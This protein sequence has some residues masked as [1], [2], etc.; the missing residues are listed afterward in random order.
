MACCIYLI[1][2]KVF[3]SAHLGFPGSTLVKN[4]PANRGNVGLTPRWG[5]I[6]WRRKW[7]PTPVFLPGKFYGHRR[8]M[9]YSPWDCKELDMTEGLTFKKFAFLYSSYI[10]IYIYMYIYYIYVCVCIYI[11]LKATPKIHIAI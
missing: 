8:P 6:P 7:Q 10:Y 3:F 4:P 5:K 11:Y 1:V 2:L 9:G